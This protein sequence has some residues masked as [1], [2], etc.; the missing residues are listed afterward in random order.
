MRRFW[1]NNALSIVLVVLFLVFWLAQA[2]TGWAVHNEELQ[3]LGQRPL[4]WGPYLA[5]AHFWS[6]TAE[7]WESEFLQMAAFVTLT[8]YLRQRGSAESN[9]YPDEQTPEQRQKDAQDKAQRGFWRRNSLS[10]V[11][12]GLFL[13]SLA[14]HL[15]SSWTDN[16]HEKQAR[17]QEALN[18]G[19]F[20]GQPEFWFESFQNWQSEFLAVVAIVVLTIF[21]RQVGSS[22]S[23]ALTDPNHKTGDA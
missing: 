5:S 16:N 14:L 19:A 1:T 20:M 12:T 11:L 22:Q 13:G 10:V 9:P 6:A 21:L 7:N 23:K 15:L 2:L 17:G 3:T 8:V 18:L 4:G